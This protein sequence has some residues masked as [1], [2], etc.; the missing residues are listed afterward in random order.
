MIPLMKLRAA[1]AISKQ[2]VTRVEMMARAGSTLHH[3]Q[4]GCSLE[5]SESKSCSL[6]S[7]RFFLFSEDTGDYISNCACV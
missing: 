7:V 5:V 1:L 4:E 6:T 3:F 2:L